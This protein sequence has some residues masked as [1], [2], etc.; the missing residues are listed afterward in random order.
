MKAAHILRLSVWAALTLY[1][2]ILSSCSMK[3]YCYQVARMESNN[4]IQQG[5]ELQYK[6]EDLCISYNLWAPGGSM[7]F[8]VY[9]QSDKDLFVHLSQSFMIKNGEALDYYQERQDFEFSNAIYSETLYNS[10]SISEGKQRVL[11]R[12]KGQTN[13]S[14]NWYGKGKSHIEINGKVESHIDIESWN[15]L[16]VAAYANTTAHAHSRSQGSI[17]KATPVVC[18]PPN[19]YKLLG[20]FNVSNLRIRTGVHPIDYP[21]REAKVASWQWNDSPLCITNR[22]AYSFDKEG[23]ELHYVENLFWLSEVNNY[24]E[25][26]AVE[27][28]STATPWEYFLIY[29]YLI[30]EKNKNWLVK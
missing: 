9:N 14:T 29:E 7:L 8:F 19:S 13:I 12:A 25:K 17:Y 24:H 4:L 11:E 23:K 22:I 15:T 6:N 2:V 26:Y 21:K 28:L 18:I 27:K 5:D 30:R 1:V 3:Q 10:F 16:Q 20:E